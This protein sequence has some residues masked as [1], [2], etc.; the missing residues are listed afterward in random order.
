MPTKPRAPSPAS[1]AGAPAISASITPLPNSRPSTTASVWNAA[2]SSGGML[3]NL[4]TASSETVTRR[5]FLPSSTTGSAET[6]TRRSP[7]AASSG[8][9]LAWRAAAPGAKSAAPAAT[10]SSVDF[11][12]IGRTTLSFRL[13]KG[14]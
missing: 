14:E 11:I 10:T 13:P 7:V 12:D 5:P 6:L 8:R 9:V 4:R 2:C 1:G 3:F